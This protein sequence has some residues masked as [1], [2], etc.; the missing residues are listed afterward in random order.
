M[1]QSTGDPSSTVGER[2]GSTG[3][4]PSTV[5]V[6]E[7]SRDKG[8]QAGADG[9]RVGPAEVEGG[10]V[11]TQDDGDAKDADG[12]MDERDGGGAWPSN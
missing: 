3:D 5:G 6:R 11:L 8:I 10:V 9:D 12:A 7:G 2:E 1:I 4:P